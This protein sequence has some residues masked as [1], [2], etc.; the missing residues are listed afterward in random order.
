M[1]TATANSQHAPS[2]GHAGALQPRAPSFQAYT[3]LLSSHRGEV[4]IFI[5]HILKRVIV[6]L[7][8]FL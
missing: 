4:D 7:L 1:T 3:T 2:S 8:N 5:A 6:T